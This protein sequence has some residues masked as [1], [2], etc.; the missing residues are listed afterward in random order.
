MQWERIFSFAFI[1]LKFDIK[2]EKEH[3]NK[4]NITALMRDGEKVINNDLGMV[5]VL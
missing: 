3:E 1:L 5:S 2:K 4:F